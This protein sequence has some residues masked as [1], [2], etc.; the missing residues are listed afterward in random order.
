M[1]CIICFDVF[2]LIRFLEHGRYSSQ[3]IKLVNNSD[4]TYMTFY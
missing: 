2:T 4:V 1:V 3:L